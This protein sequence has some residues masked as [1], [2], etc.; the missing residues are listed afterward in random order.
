LNVALTRAKHCLYIFGN[1]STLK[2]D[3]TWKKFIE[4]MENKERLQLFENI[5]ELE[6]LLNNCIGEV[7]EIEKKSKK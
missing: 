2:I 3:D 4:F 7:E 1:T 6:S 5:K